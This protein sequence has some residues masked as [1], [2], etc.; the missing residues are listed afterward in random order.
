MPETMST[1]ST[2]AA[3]I[4][5]RCFLKRAQTN[6]RWEAVKYASLAFW[7]CAVADVGMEVRL[8]VMANSEYS[9]GYGDQEWPKAHR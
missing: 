4:A 8:S 2:A 9:Y 1:I 5:A 7:S 3:T 6:C